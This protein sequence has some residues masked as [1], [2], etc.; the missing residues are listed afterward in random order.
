MVFAACNSG[1]WVLQGLRHPWDHLGWFSGTWA[2]LLLVHA[3]VV[4]RLRP[5]PEAAAT[6]TPAAQEPPP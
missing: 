2:V 3:S 5:A 6:T 1:L 4:I